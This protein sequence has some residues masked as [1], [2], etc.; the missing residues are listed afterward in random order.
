MVSHKWYQPIFIR[1]GWYQIHILY[2]TDY[3]CDTVYLDGSAGPTLTFLRPAAG[4][5]HFHDHLYMP[6]EPDMRQFLTEWSDKTM[7]LV[8]A[9]TKIIY[10]KEKEI[11]NM[12]TRAP[13]AGE[14]PT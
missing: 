1:V 2:L 13:R 12:Q 4:W 5:S 11:V 7:C 10:A 9:W 3:A 8:N 6:G 14:W